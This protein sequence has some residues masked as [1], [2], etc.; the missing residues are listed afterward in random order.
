MD[1]ML[2]DLKAMRESLGLTPVKE[3]EKVEIEIDDYE[4]DH[5]QSENNCFLMMRSPDEKEAGRR[6]L[7]ASS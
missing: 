2:L 4:H 3:K 5:D 1:D 6:P 7:Q